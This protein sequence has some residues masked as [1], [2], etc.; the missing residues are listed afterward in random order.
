MCSTWLIKSNL[1]L[2][3]QARKLQCRACTRQEMCVSFLSELPGFVSCEPQPQQ[4]DVSHWVASLALW[5]PLAL[6]QAFLEHTGASGHCKKRGDDSW[7][8][9]RLGRGCWQP[10]LTRELRG[11][12]PRRECQKLGFAS[13]PSEKVQSCISW[14]ERGLRALSI[15]SVVNCSPLQDCIW[16]TN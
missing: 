12:V 7:V 2:K 8:R 15:P 3:L 6:Q 11:D 13:L 4:A 14:K 9:L 10:F 16:S 5:G 1:G